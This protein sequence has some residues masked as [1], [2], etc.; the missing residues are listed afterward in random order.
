MK[1]IQVK[2]K[3]FKA[4]TPSLARYRRMMDAGGN[5]D[6]AFALNR[7]RVTIP[8]ELNDFWLS[9]F[10]VTNDMYRDFITATG[11]RRPHGKLVNFYWQR[12]SGVPWDLDDFKGDDLPVTGVNDVDVQAFCKWFSEKEGRQYR[13]P[14]IYEFEF[15]NRAGTDTRFWWGNTPDVRKMNFGVSLIGHPTP[16][17]FYPSNPWGF[18]DI[19]GNTWQYCRDGGRYT[20]MGSAFNCP[21]RW[22]GADAWGNFAEGSPMMRLLTSG[23]RLACDKNQGAARPGDL[24]KP[25]IMAAGGS[26]PKFPDLD[27]TVGERIDMGPIPTNAAFFMITA[28]GTWVLNNKRSIDRGKTWQPCEQLGEAFC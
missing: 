15:A 25:T 6:V 19:E 11:Y 8:I 14:T 10:P 27:I 13:A 4:W 26:G 20:A 16:V 18:Y 1:M 3:P 5:A 9:E 24:K 12:S 21:Q 28:G 7:P 17:G 22:T 2:A 23:F